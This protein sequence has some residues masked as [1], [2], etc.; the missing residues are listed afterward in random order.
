MR[1]PKKNNLDKATSFLHLTQHFSANQRGAVAVLFA[2]S[3]IPLMVMAGM[4]VDLSRAYLVKT[5][6]SHA[7][8]SAGLAVGSM[9]TTSTNSTYLES[10]FTNFVTANYPDAQEGTVHNLTFV[11]N[12]GIISVTGKAT[13]ETVFMGL[14][15]VNSITVSANA[16]VVVETSGLELV[17]VLDNTGSMSSN[18]KMSDMKAASLEL[19]D[20]L[21]G[22]ETAP[23]LL[24]VALVPF[25]N[26]VN[27]GTASSAYVTNPSAYDW[28]SSSWGGCVM[29]RAYPAD[30]QDTDIATDGQWVPFW[31]TKSSNRNRYCPRPITPLTNNRTTL[32]TEINAM[33]PLGS[34]HINLGAIWG[35]RALSPTAP[36]TEGAAYNDPDWNKAAIIL[37][38]GDNTMIDSYYSAFG[39][40]SEQNLGT[41]NA[42]AAADELDSRLLEVCTG[43]KNEGIIVYTIAFGTSIASSTANLLTSCASSAD[44]YYESPDSATL[45]LAFRAIGAE[46]KNLHLS[47]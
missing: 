15:G 44:K 5:R 28:G 31:N 6:L 10:Q 40:L 14:I 38:D 26:T 17:M 2:L 8:D 18:N 23:D 11:D 13:V 37:T 25:D 47:Q 36:F 32:E 12:G 39:L 41:S 33:S 46:L 1:S 34:T 24:K 45:S 4:A 30:V 9:R 29:A 27:I 20:I 19:I 35:W 7:L 22:N 3:V 42:N 43:M 16:E 21:F